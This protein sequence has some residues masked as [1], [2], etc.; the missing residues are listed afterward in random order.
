MKVRILIYVLAVIAANFLVLYFGK[1]GLWFSS[2]LLIPFDFVMRCYFH[3]KWRG[4]ELVYK[5]GMLIGAGSLAT[6]L[7]NF[8]TLNIAVASA[9]GFVIAN[10]AAGLFYQAVIKR[11]KFIKVNGSDIVAICVDSLFFQYIA[12]GMLD[13]VVTVGQIIVKICGGLLWYYI[14]FHGFKMQLPTR[15]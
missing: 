2:M 1:Y 8:N 5:L 9:V 14:L 10:I 3:E 7:I 6:Y 15:E 12:F 13:P 11:S 4:Q